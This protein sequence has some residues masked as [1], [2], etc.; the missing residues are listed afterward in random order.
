MYWAKAPTRRRKWV[1][2]WRVY[3]PII[4]NSCPYS[5][6]YKCSNYIFVLISDNWIQLICLLKTCSGTSSDVTLTC[7]LCLGRESGPLSAPPGS[8]HT[9]VLAELVAMLLPWS[10]EHPL[11]NDPNRCDVCKRHFVPL[12]HAVERHP[13]SSLDHHGSPCH[14]M[15]PSQGLCVSRYLHWFRRCRRH[16]FPA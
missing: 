3:D 8:R 11:Q 13:G 1:S 10:R 16:R 7:F 9:T 12:G 14:W 2:A 5:Y 4:V 15:F 6:D